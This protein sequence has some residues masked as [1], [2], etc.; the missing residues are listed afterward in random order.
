M[1]RVVVTGMGTI[2]PIG[3]NVEE[4]WKNIKAG[5]IGIDTI[6]Q[7][8]ATNTATKIAAEVKDF[9]ASD[10]FSGK[11]ARKMA[12]FTQF[13]VA[14]SV[15]AMNDAGLA[16]DNFDHQRAGCILGCGIGGLD[17]TEDNVKGMVDRGPIAGIAPM[18]IPKLIS[19]EGPANVSITHKLHGPCFALATACA[20][21]T[22]A[23]GYALNTIRTGMADIMVTGGT[24][25]TI[26]EF[27]VGSFNKL[28]ALS[29]RNDDPK[30]ACRPFDK[31]RD[32][33]I[34]GEGAGILILEELEHAKKRGATIYAE[35]AG[36][37][38][39]C[40]ADHLTAPDPEGKGG[41]ESM[42]I[43]VKDAGLEMEDI[44]YINA[45]GTST[46]VNDPC[47]TLAIKAAFG[48]HAKKIKISSTKAM[49]GHMLGATGGVEAIVCIKAINDSYVPPTLNLEEPDEKCDLDYVPNKGIEM[50]VNAALSDNLGFGGHNGSIV[51]KKYKG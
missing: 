5:E 48:D 31:D 1:K 23:I 4:F 29:T 37:G 14:A 18:T 9:K 35:L 19:N 6:T 22:D 26:T 7:F 11:A 12:R 42:R 24:E 33:F 16:E 47:E 10:Y 3:H 21:G 2:S 30:A 50:E 34:M 38:M 51:F 8:D 39:T 44:D 40:D 20:S 28:L 15:E 49:H 25:A 32:G 13:A 43:A 41:A 36:Y 46:P 45:H 17:V 27:A